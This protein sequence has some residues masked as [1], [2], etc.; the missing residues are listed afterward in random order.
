M[1]FR[2]KQQINFL[3][4]CFF[5]TSKKIITSIDQIRKIIKIKN[6]LITAHKKN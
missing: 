6:K 4:E 2:T 5:D 1:N 3:K